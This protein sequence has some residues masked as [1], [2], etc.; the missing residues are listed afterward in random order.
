MIGPVKHRKDDNDW[1]TCVPVCVK[2]NKYM[3]HDGG[4]T[5]CHCPDCGAASHLRNNY[6][7]D[8]SSSFHRPPFGPCDFEKEFLRP[9]QPRVL[10]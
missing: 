10:A 8:C 4:G 1:C 3:T 5:D 2:C 7:R 6:T 9:L